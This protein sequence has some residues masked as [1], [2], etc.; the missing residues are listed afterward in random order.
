MPE[1]AVNTV[2]ARLVLSADS[3]AMVGIGL[4][5]ERLARREIP[6]MLTD[7]KI[8]AAKPVPKPQKLF[9]EKGL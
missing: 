9:D 5:A 3:Q 6:P 1:G 4:G 2:H 8:R 7:T